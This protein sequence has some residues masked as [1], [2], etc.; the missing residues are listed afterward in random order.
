MVFWKYTAEDRH[1]TV[2]SEIVL[3]SN[4]GGL[5]ENF[6]NRITCLNTGYQL[7]ELF[8]KDQE[9]GGP[10]WR[11]YVTGAGLWSLSRGVTSPESGRSKEKGDRRRG[12]REMRK[13]QTPMERRDTEKKNPAISIQK[14]TK[15]GQSKNRILLYNKHCIIAHGHN[16]ACSTMS[17]VF[18]GWGDARAYATAGL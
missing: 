15:D 11:K 12:E 10:S 18:K 13:E 7:V 8:E 17:H 6:C 5:N 1:L 2:F 3:K 14:P 9:C 16:K 4:C